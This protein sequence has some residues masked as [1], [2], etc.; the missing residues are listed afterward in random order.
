[1]K[2]IFFAIASA[3]MLFASCSKVDDVVPS[4]DE[5]KFKA[6]YPV[7]KATGSAFEAGD[8]MGVYVSRYDG[9]KV[10]PL[11]ITGNYANNAKS[12]FDGAAWKTTPAIYWEEGKFDV[13]AYYPYAK[14]NSVDE[15][16]F[17]VALD[18]TV[19]ETSDALST[20]EQSDFLWAEAKGVS[21]MAEVP[22][23]FSHKMSKILINLV[24]GEEY[25]GELPETAVVRVHNTVP[26]AIVDLATG[27]VVKNSHEAAKSIT[28]LQV[29]ETSY[30]AIIV[31]QRLENKVPLVEVITNGVSYL[32][33]SRF[34]FRSG[35]QHTV[36][37][38]LSDN[39]D[40][41]RIEVGGEIEG[42]EKE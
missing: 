29:A 26:A 23:T 11:Q 1:M 3:A 17:S 35:I 14:P 28:A 20:Y 19:A 27:N 16:D 38:V 40:K 9:E 24:K 30:S 7:T 5:M 25:T 34:V 22:L 33:E 15:Y 2:K 42:W 21:Q 10:L 32:V 18:Q 36:N 39:P 37:V 8:A 13:Y 41:V 31:P 4:S 12:V 6:E